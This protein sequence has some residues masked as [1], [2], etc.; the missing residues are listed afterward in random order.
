MRLFLVVS[1]TF[2]PLLH[3]E[4]TF[5]TTKSVEKAFGGGE[6]SFDVDNNWAICM[7]RN[8]TIEFD[9]SIEDYA[10]M[11]N[12]TLMSLSRKGGGSVI[13][14]EGVFPITVPISLPKKTCIIGQGKDK[15]TLRVKDK[16][17]PPYPFKGTIIAHKVDR[18][19]LVG[20]TIDGNAQN[21]Y[22]EHIFHTLGRVGVYQERVHE[23]YLLNVKSVNSFRHGCTYHHF[24]YRSPS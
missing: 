19:S 9:G 23:S 7:A 1:L 3:A 21:Q 24:P 13:I 2:I 6:F 4:R 15:T 10:K 14:G 22:L 16:S 18:V 5:K 8:E 17:Y 20:L 12:E 11:L